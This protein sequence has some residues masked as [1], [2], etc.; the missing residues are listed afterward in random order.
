[1]GT[2]LI[3]KLEWGVD[4]AVFLQK[5]GTFDYVIASDVI[6]APRAIL[7]LFD[8][9]HSLLKA[10]GSFILANNVSRMNMNNAS[11]L[12]AINSTQFQKTEINIS[13]FMKVL[14]PTETKLFIFKKI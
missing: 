2:I 11:F 13:E 1:M 8:T 14:P 4:L 7:P 3:E 5:H 10:D 9:C 12:N 6:Y